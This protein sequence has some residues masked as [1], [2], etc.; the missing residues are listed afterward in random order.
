MVTQ[1]GKIVITLRNGE[2]SYF[3]SETLRCQILL[4]NILVWSTLIVF[5]RNQSY[6][7]TFTI[8]SYSENT[9]S[10]TDFQEII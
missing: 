7:N 5:S 9:I 6:Q 10:K 4:S 2:I 1:F 3:V 8:T